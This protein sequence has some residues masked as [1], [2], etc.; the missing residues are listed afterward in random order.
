MVDRLK[1]GVLISGSGSNLQAIMD[2]CDKKN[3][4]AEVV[5]VGS[6]N[7]EATGLL[8]AKNSNIPYFV[9]DY[10]KI[11]KNCKKTPEF[12]L[13][14]DYDLN[15][16]KASQ[17]LFPKNSVKEKINF[18]LLSRARAEA[19]LLN[20]MCKHQF[21]LLV[22]AGFMHKLTPYFI[23]KVNTPGKLPKIMNI[24]PAILPSF[25]GICGY[26]DTFN[27]GCK[28]GGCTVHFVD[29]GEDTGPIIGQKVFSITPDDTIDSI[30][31]KGLEKEWALFPECIQ[32][33]AN[34]KLKLETYSYISG[35]GKQITRTVVKQQSG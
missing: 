20:K 30:K 23:S 13:P 17:N 32:L 31:R 26:E 28:V 12:K 27:Y 33:Y 35:L 9:V 14:N 10:K 6:D 25:P 7:K 15:K 5:F 19:E 21:D 2:Q 22:L 29:F 16:I 1:V 8:K 24:H 34:N 18:F 3:I 4:N 11:I